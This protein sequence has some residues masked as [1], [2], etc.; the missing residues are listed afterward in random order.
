MAKED[1]DKY[2]KLL[3][4]KS[5]TPWEEIRRTY[6]DLIK[7]WHPDRFA[8]DSRLHKLA[9]EKTKEINIAFKKI[10]E[11][12][13]SIKF[14]YDNFGESPEPIQKPAD[15]PA[16]ERQREKEKK[17]PSREDLKR[18][19]EEWFSKAKAVESGNY[20]TVVDYLSHAIELDPFL[21]KA[22]VERGLAHVELKEY[23]LAIKD[24]NEA[25]QLNN[26]SFE[27]FRGRATAQYESG[28][29]S[30]AIKDFTTAIE[31]EPARYSTLY[32]Y[33]GKAYE[34]AGFMAEAAMDFRINENLLKSA[35][36]NQSVDSTAAT[37][38]SRRSY[39]VTHSI[40]V[41]VICLISL[42]L[43][44]SYDYLSKRTNKEAGKPGTPEKTAPD[45]LIKEM[46]EKQRIGDFMKEKYDAM[47]KSQANERKTGSTSAG[48]K[49]HL[50]DPFI[51]I[52][53]M[54]EKKPEASTKDKTEKELKTDLPQK[55]QKKIR[56]EPP[57]TTEI[58]KD[59]FEQWKKIKELEKSF[60]SFLER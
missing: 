7:V 50:R 8:G 27:S 2:Y 34:K 10:E 5:G 47:I 51:K 46:I 22:Y 49:E 24:F 35:S 52:V 54:E 14:S 4:V 40:F 32:F 60:P 56:E 38:I 16:P 17:K 45:A 15:Q 23:D 28:N 44:F 13:L 39:W 59:T 36:N 21:E 25:V 42:L 55:D 19:A 3:E 41:F 6:R 1:I 18:Q 48:R 31:M 12:R 11:D 57:E 58:R 37:E 20:R 26:S 9:E 30:F 53:S 33:R 43:Y 29:Y